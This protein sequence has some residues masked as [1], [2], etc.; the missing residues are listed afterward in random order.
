M[1]ED[2]YM[3]MQT[4]T[5]AYVHTKLLRVKSDP[6]TFVLRAT[7]YQ[8]STLSEFRTGLLCQVKT[9]L[10]TGSSRMEKLHHITVL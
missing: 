5:H 2:T 10:G 1:F 8:L 4:H 7:E 3:H 6:I 9:G